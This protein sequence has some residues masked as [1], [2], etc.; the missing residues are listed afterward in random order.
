MKKVLLLVLALFMVAGMVFA[1]GSSQ[2]NQQI[3]LRF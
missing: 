1:T 3:T 2:S